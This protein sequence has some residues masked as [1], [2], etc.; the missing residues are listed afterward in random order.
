MLTLLDARYNKKRYEF[1]RKSIKPN[2]G[3][4]EPYMFM[5]TCLNCEY[6]T[7][8]QDLRHLIQHI[9]FKEI[10]CGDKNTRSY[11]KKNKKE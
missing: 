8:C 7:V 5:P 10:T 6:D 1:L 3:L 11:H 4:F 9:E 2:C